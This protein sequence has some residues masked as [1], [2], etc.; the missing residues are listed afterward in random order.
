[1]AN[2]IQISYEWRFCYGIVHATNDAVANLHKAGLDEATYE[3]YIC[4]A[5]FLRAWAYSRLNKFFWGVPLYLEPVTNEECTRT[6]SS[7]EDIWKAVTD[8]L[9]YCIDNQYMPDNTLTENYGR[10]SKGAA[11]ALRGDGL[12]VESPYRRGRHDSGAGL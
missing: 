11:Y 8:D 12:H 3:R 1:M 6:Q 2:D 4:E 9:T 7:A 5:R 10:P